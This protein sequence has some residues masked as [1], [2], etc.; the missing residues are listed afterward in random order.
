MLSD[1]VCESNCTSKKF[2]FVWISIFIKVHDAR[3]S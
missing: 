3:E 1:F 2:G